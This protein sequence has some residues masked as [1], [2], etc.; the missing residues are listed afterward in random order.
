MH[1]IKIFLFILLLIF[2]MVACIEPYDPNIESQTSTKIIVSGQVTDQEGYQYVS[3]S[4]VSQIED[5]QYL[6][7]NGCVI[8]ILDDEDNSFPLEEYESGKYRVWMGAENL[9]YG[10]AYQLDIYTT[11]GEE[12]KSNYDEMPSGPEM[13]S[14]YYVQESI[15][16]DDPEQPLQGIQFYIDVDANDG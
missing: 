13:D 7:L 8:T 1:Q 3:V 10:R 6:P 2:E 11:T 9:K 12:I 4:Y 14:I 5:P 16:S 15:L